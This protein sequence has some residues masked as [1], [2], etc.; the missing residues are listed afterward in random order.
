MLMVAASLLA[1]PL[2][3]GYILW[4]ATKR[5]CPF[6][7]KG[8]IVFREPLSAWQYVLLAF[9]L[10]IWIIL[11]AALINP[12]IESMIVES[13]FAWV[14][15]VYFI[16]SFTENISDYSRSTLIASAL[17]L[18]LINGIV[19]PIVEELYFRGYLL[20]R[21]SQL[22]RCAPLVNTVLFSLCH[23]FSPWQNPLRILAFT[24]VYYVVWWKENI[25][26]GI[27]VHCL[28][29]LLGSVGLLILILQASPVGP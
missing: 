10:L 28:G 21:L 11:V 22:G 5:N 8:I 23:F 15:D 27:V 13:L 26:I 16:T 19:G 14:P 25:Y 29:N 9:P 6:S 24:P 7:L 3:L 2:E 18:I 17:L 1:L 12:P 20:P 4:E